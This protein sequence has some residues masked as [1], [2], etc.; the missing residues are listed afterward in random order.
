MRSFVGAAVVVGIVGCGDGV[1]YFEV[2]GDAAICFSGGVPSGAGV[3]G[4]V[5][6][7][8]EPDFE[9]IEQDQE[10]PLVVP[11][12]Q[13]NA[14]FLI[15][16]RIR[17]LHPGDPTS[18]SSPDNP[19][20]LLSVWNE[21]GERI[22]TRTCGFPLSYR[23]EL[24]GDDGVT[25]EGHDLGHARALML[26]N[27]I[28]EPAIDGERVRLMVEVLDSRGRYAAADVWVIARWSPR[29]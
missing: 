1:D 7:G 9:P 13:G 22:D 5:E 25:V 12:G 29:E 14:M 24:I 16:P 15:H 21:D 19:R 18:N 17:G 28:D 2:E 8:L 23:H 11:R 26:P 20:T 4:E 6:I 10:V 3:V 27:T